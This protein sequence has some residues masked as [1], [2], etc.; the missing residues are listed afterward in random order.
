MSSHTTSDN[1]RPLVIKTFK[2]PPV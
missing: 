1:T 2:V